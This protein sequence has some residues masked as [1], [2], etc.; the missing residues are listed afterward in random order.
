MSINICLKY[1]V[2]PTKTS[3]LK[4][5]LKQVSWKTVTFSK[6]LEY[7]FLVKSTIKENATFSYKIA[8]S[9]TN[10][11]TNRIANTKWTYHK[12]GGFVTNYFVF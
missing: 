1:F 4:N 3:F 6:K 7:H 5:K 11:N 10:V 9:K 2:A 8:V 12:K